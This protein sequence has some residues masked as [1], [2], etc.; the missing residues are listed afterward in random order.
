[1]TTK[2]RLIKYGIDLDLISLDEFQMINIECALIAAEMNGF[3]SCLKR[4]D[5]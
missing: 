2:E 1:M 4:E 3:N 5:K